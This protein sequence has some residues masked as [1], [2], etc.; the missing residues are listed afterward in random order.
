MQAE[1]LVAVHTEILETWKWINQR[2]ISHTTMKHHISNFI[3]AALCTILLGACTNYTEEAIPEFKPLPIN[4]RT[5]HVS[6]ESGEEEEDSEQKE[7]NISTQNVQTRMEV[8]GISGGKV[9]YKWSKRDSIGVFLLNVQ[10]KLV[11]TS[12]L[13]TPDANIPNKAIF[14]FDAEFVD[15]SGNE[16]HTESYDSHLD[17]FLYYP[18]NSSLVVPQVYTQGSDAGEPWYGHEYLHHNNG[19]VYRVPALQTMLEHEIGRQGCTQAMSRYGVCYDF[20]RYTGS[21]G[22]KFTMRHTNAYFRVRVTGSQYDS[23]AT[24]GL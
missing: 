20:M 9:T 7:Q 21:E 14:K 22:D 6:L 19:L 15:D 10:P 17:M 11:N 4:Y 5:V 23:T 24:Q 3:I 8:D 13:G 12:S 2:L 16:N 18:Y 1:T